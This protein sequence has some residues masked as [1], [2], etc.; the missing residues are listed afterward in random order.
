MK[1]SFR[2]ALIRH[3]ADTHV[4]LTELAK[5][6]GVSLDTLMKLNTGR[7]ATTSV[8]QAMAISAF[9]GLSLESFTDP[10]ISAVAPNLE[11]VLPRLSTDERKML[12]SQVRGMLESRGEQLSTELKPTAMNENEVFQ[13]NL[14]RT[15]KE[16]GLNAAEL[17]KKAGLNP[18]AVKDIEETRAQSPRLST[19]FKLAAALGADVGEMVG[20]GP[21]PTINAELARYLSQY[22]DDEQKRILVALSTLLPAKDKASGPSKTAVR[23][24]LTLHEPPSS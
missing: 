22:S 15:M 12:L 24:A 19:V 5:G 1:Q 18:R 10:T 13:R 23:N 3:L 14:L 21:R 11:Q 20:L 2:D 7:I 4:G 8:E 17:S 16:K 6:A 9:F